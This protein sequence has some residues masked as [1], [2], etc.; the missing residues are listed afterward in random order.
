MAKTA[1]V[2]APDRSNSTAILVFVGIAVIIAGTGVLF[3]LNKKKKDALKDKAPVKKQITKDGKTVFVYVKEPT[4]DTGGGTNQTQ[5]SKQT[6]QNKSVI[7]QQ[8]QQSENSNMP[9][10]NEA[11]GN[12]FRLWVNNK[13]P[14]YAKSIKLDKKG[15]FNNS[16][17]MQAWDKFREE[18]IM[19]DTPSAQVKPNTKSTT[20]ISNTPKESTT[21]TTPTSS[22]PFTNSTDGNAFRGWINDTYPV[23]AKLIL[24]DRKGS[25]NNS[26][27]KT[28]WKKYGSEY[29]APIS[30]PNVV[31]PL[32]VSDSPNYTPIAPPMTFTSTS[33]GNKFRAWVNKNYPTYAK[34]IDLSKTG[35]Y[36]NS[37]IKKAWAKYGTEYTSDSVVSFTGVPSHLDLN[38]NKSN[39]DV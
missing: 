3:Y 8:E 13:Y 31:Y 12:D 14:S 16:Y 32:P 37:Y 2:I 30:N 19:D 21:S 26:F 15:S 27:I 6:Q 39:I 29:S 22:I 17:I 11:Q 36:S 20:P 10:S 25:Y 34:S 4:K 23:Y 5:Q 33:Q 38:V 9:F 35:S 1:T 24:L 28:A 18:Y 7:A